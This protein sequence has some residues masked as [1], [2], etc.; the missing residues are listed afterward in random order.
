MSCPPPARPAGAHPSAV[1]HSPL[2]ASASVGE[3]AVIGRDVVF[4]ENVVVY[5]GCVIGDG[6]ARI[7]MKKAASAEVEVNRI[8]KGELH[9]L[10][11]PHM[12]VGHAQ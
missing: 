7:E 5:P 11:P 6:V 1:V 9:F 2:P 10:V 3:N 8:G 12:L 4:G